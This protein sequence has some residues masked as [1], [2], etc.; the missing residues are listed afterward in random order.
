MR[1]DHRALHR[2]PLI[3][4][5]QDGRLAA[6]MKKVIVSPW[7]AVRRRIDLLGARR[8]RT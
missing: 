6:E 2:S 5:D 7:P 8:W 3:T 1:S 4:K